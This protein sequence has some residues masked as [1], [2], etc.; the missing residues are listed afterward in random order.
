V[1]IFLWLSVGLILLSIYLG[2]VLAKRK[3]LNP[4][5]WSMMGGVFGPFM[6]PFLILARPRPP[7]ANHD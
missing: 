5:F 6:L 4:L 3:G 7:A 1:S 2:H